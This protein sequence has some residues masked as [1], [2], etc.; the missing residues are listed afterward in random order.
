[1]AGYQY[2]SYCWVGGEAAVPGDI[3]VGDRLRS[4]DDRAHQER[5]GGHLYGRAGI[6]ARRQ[7][8]DTGYTSLSLSFP[9]CIFPTL[10]PPP[11][12]ISTS[13]VKAPLGL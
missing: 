11:V 8:S 7:G 10:G 1:M 9:L 12:R 2:S 3:P 5:G 6:R 4:D 13:E